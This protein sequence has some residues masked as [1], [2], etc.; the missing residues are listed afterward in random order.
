DLEVRV[1][2]G[3]NAAA[4]DLF[5]CRHAR[6]VLEAFGRAFGALGE[7]AQT[8][9]QERFLDQAVGG[10]AQSGKV[11]PVRLSLF[12]EM[13]KGRPWTPAALKE[14]GGAEGIGVAFLEETFSARTAPPEHRQHQK[15]ARAVLGVLLPD[16]GSDLKGY[17]RSRQE[18]LEASGY[19]HRPDEFTAL[20]RIL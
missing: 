4:I 6:K 20:M 19:V 14:V 3:T 5:D 15:G 12:C 16:P 13:V 10:L 18:L 8:P 17:M 9:D 1:V 2:E 7:G 11:I